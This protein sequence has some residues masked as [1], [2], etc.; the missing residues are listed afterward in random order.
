MNEEFHKH[1]LDKYL[2][3]CLKIYYLEK[4]RKIRR[5]VGAKPSRAFCGWEQQTPVA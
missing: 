2:K 4:N 5:T 1:G 3:K